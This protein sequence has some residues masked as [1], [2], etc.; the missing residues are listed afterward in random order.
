MTFSEPPF[1]TGLQD[2][3]VASDSRRLSELQW[4]ASA[5]GIEQ[6]RRMP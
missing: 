1:F 3:N 5:P 2:F 6:H 4:N